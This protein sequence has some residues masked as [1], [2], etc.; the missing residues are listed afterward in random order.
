LCYGDVAA[1]PAD[2]AQT[3]APS[4]LVVEDDP[5]QLMWLID[6]LRDAGFEALGASDG[7]AALRVLRSR[8]DLRIVLTDGNLPGA[9]DGLELVAR[10][11]K[12]FPDLGVIFLSGHIEPDPARPQPHAYLSKP[13]DP[14]RLV[15]TVRA[16]IALRA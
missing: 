8:T 16:A 11:R 7:E 12:E 2:S 13:A 4:V 15:D 10:V 6:L 9:V 5:L 3:P 1:Q 14:S